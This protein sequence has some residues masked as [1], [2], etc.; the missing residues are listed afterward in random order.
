MMAQ[1]TAWTSAGG[2]VLVTRWLDVVLVTMRGQVGALAAEPVHA[3][4]S[5][6]LSMPAETW[7]DFWELD[8]Y[9]TAV[10]VRC[11]AALLEN[12][13]NV[14]AVHICMRNPLVA[15][16]VEVA[17]MVTG[18][19]AM[20]YADQHAFNAALSARVQRAA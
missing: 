14:R 4:L 1:T 7:F 5:Q 13:P 18:L 2:T 15:M 3:A 8:G 20:K 10:R 19:Q 16:G 17:L 12:K 6:R 11:T 9:K